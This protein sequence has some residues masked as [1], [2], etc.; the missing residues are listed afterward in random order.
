[1][2][3]CIWFRQVCQP[4]PRH[5]VYILD[6]LALQAV[7]LLDGTRTAPLAAGLLYQLSIDDEGRAAFC[8]CPGGLNRLLDSILR[9]L[10]P[11]NAGRVC[12]HAGATACCALH[13]ALLCWRVE[14]CAA[15]VYILRNTPGTRRELETS[16]ILNGG[17]SLTLVKQ[18]V[19]CW[20]WN[21]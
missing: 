17:G 3:G 9:T 4:C 19:P 10:G 14:P 11:R 16:L 8:F 12:C 7:P 5:A 18:L 2:P 20:V 6:A 21:W 15:A 13:R 1:M